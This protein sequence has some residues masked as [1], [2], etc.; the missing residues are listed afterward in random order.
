MFEKIN[1]ITIKL[2]TYC[3]LACEYCHQLTTDKVKSQKFSDYQGLYDF[4]LKIP[5]EPEVEVTLTGGE[6]SLI[7]EEYEKAF[8][9]FRKLNRKIE[10]KF[11]FAVVSNGTNVDQLL[12]FIDKGMLKALKTTISWDGLYTSSLS[13]RP[14]SKEFNDEF[15]K[16][17]LKKIGKSPYG[18]Q[19]C[20]SH[21]ITPETVMHIPKSVEWMIENGL[22]N[23]GFY[24]I[25]EANYHSLEFVKNF[26]TMCEE[27]GAL[28]VN[29]FNNDE[30]R[31]KYFNWQLLFAKIS[32]DLS[33]TAMVANTSCHKLGR[34]I[35]I[36]PFGDIY[37]CI[38]FGDH[39]ALKLGELS[40]GALQRKATNKFITDYVQAVSCKIE[41]CEN[42]H[43][44]ECPA[45]NYVHN[46]GMQNR[47]ANTCHL[48]SIEK[49]VF[50]KYFNTF[51]EDQ[52]K[53]DNKWLISMYFNEKDHENASKE[54]EYYE[55]IREFPEE[56]MMA[57]YEMSDQPTQQS[58]VIN[59]IKNWMD[60]EHQK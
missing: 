30:K 50:N 1:K 37:G 26:D 43:C 7:P 34:S 42:S 17:Q 36:D 47:M 45:A 28:F 13:R 31:F 38:Y 3:N 11:E 19:I 51:K 58:P 5:F 49:R 35:H 20:I 33:P 32:D 4:L 9:V 15:F 18:E 54:I 24:Y 10:T 6:I 56:S 23:F 40:H 27:L 22:K 14:K 29:N 8:K 55:K 16:E 44:Y 59:H 39:R 60:N 21:A 41:K 2:T 46:G 52:I 25:H 53:K 12:E 57:D 48:L